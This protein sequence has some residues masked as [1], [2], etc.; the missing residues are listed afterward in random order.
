[1]ANFAATF[2]DGMTNTLLV[3]EGATP[4]PWT[5]PDDVIMPKTG[6]PKLGS[7]FAD[8]FVCG[9]ADGAVRTLPRNLDPQTLRWAIDPRDGNI[10]KLPP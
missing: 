4:V 9:F 7:Q 8:V 1:M 10:L 3:V 2:L 6:A 5:K